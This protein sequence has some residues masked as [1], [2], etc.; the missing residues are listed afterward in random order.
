MAV[1]HLAGELILTQQAERMTAMHDQE[2]TRSKA[3]R[4]SKSIR[5]LW[6]F[7]S[8][9]RRLADCNTWLAE[10]RSVIDVFDLMTVI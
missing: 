8:R 3:T 5:L 4:M 2:R 9:A 6:S 10:N 1:G 7:R